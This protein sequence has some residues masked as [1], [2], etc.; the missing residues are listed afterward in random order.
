MKKNTPSTSK[1]APL[2]ANIEKLTKPQRIGIYAGTLVVLIGM[3]VWLLF[4]PRYGQIDQL[5]NQLAKVEAELAKAKKN[6]R[7]LNDWRKKMKQK[8]SQYKTV[9]RALPEKEEIPSLLAGISQAGKD[10]GLEFILFQPKKE[11]AKGFYAEI[12]V[13]IGVTGGYHQIAVFFDKVANLPRIVNLRRIKMAPGSQKDAGTL[14][15]ACQAVT[16][17]FVESTAPQG[18]RGRRTK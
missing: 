2:F 9:M 4:W 10:S 16:Y 6:A 18:K 7:E 15:M 11:I 5:E 17:K 1:L 14:S 13:E 8:E 12:P 3:S